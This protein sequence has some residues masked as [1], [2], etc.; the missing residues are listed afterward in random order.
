MVDTNDTQTAEVPSERNIAEFK[1]IVSFA[2]RSD[3]LSPKQERA[4]NDLAQTY[5]IEVPRAFGKNSVAQGFSVDPKLIFNND[6][7]TILEIGTGQGECIAHNAKTRPSVNFLGLE[8]Y[9]PGLAHTLQRMRHTPVSNLKMVRVD[10]ADF[11][12]FC[13]PQQSLQEIWVFF[14]D[15][16]PKTR[17]HKRRL[18]TAEFLSKAARCLRPGGVLR[19]ATDWQ[20]Y[21]EQ[22]IEVISLH[23]AFDLNIE[24]TRFSAR[25]LTNFEQKGLAKGRAITDLTAVRRS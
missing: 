1:K 13:L 10:A 3:R 12:D 21:G 7:P 2:Q 4:W 18:V 19:L 9:L 17:H 16:W 22:M 14:P 15:P 24:A 20:N 11:L 8:V 6:A 5:V 25:P 23:P